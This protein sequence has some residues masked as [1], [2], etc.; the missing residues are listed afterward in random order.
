MTTLIF[1]P[2]FHTIRDHFTKHTD[3]WKVYYD[4]VEPHHETLPQ[5][6]DTKIGMFQ[7]MLVLRCLRPDK[8]RQYIDISLYKLFASRQS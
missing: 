7:K 3:L 5:E 6:W 8:V 1:V 2:R 4:S